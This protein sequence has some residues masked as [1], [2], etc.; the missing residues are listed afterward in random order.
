[1]PRVVYGM[2]ALDICVS[3]FVIDTRCSLVFSFVKQDDA[4]RKRGEHT[5]G[6]LK[7]YH[8]LNPRIEPRFGYTMR[9]EQGVNTNQEN[10]MADC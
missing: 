4:N 9:I 1:M 10:E 7:E 6:I 5:I 8:P 2:L 3:V